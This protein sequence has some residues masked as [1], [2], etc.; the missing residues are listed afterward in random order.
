MMAGRDDRCG[1][2]GVRSMRQRCPG[3]AGRRPACSSSISSSSTPGHELGRVAQQLV[4]ARR[5]SPRCRSRAPPSSRRARRARPRAGRG[6]RRSK[7][8]VCVSAGGSPRRG[9]QAQDLALDRTHRQV[10]ELAR[11]GAGRE[12]RRCRR[13]SVAR[14][15]TSAVLADLDARAARSAGAARPAARAGRRSGRRARGTRRAAS[16]RAPARAR[17]RRSAAGARRAA[18]GARAARARAPAPRPRRGRGRRRACRS[19]PAARSPSS[20]ANAGQRPRCAG[21]SSSSSGSPRVGLGDRGE[22]P[23]RDVRRARAERVALVHHDAQ[24]RCARAPGDGQPDHAAADD[25]D[26]VALWCW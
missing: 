5:R 13:A 4:D 14:S 12:R 19:V 20:A 18:R 23:R 2:P 22:H 16:A 24:A 17:A 7:R 11:P 6:S 25:G 15:A 26:V 1:R 3:V 8:T 9:A 21:P 10:G